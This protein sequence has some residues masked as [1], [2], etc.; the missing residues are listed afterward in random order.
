MEPDAFCFEGTFEVAGPSEFKMDRHYLLYAVQGTMRLETAGRRWTLP[1]A[2][3]ALI[4]ANETVIISILS[5]LKTAS[6]LFRPGFIE[7]PPSP[8]A[9]FEVTSLARE[10]ILECRSWG[11]DTELSP[12]ARRI[13]ATLGD[14]ALRLATTP[15]TSYLP[16]PQSAGLL[17]AVALTE[18]QFAGE[19]NFEAIAV[20]SGHTSRTLA[21]LF[22][23][24]MG[25][26]WRE[27]LRRIRII[28]AIEELSTSDKKV[29]TVALDVGYSSVAAFNSAFRELTGK[30]PVE[31]RNSLRA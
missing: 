8:V 18:E 9:V 23:A 6:V 20:A 12:Y 14:V 11:R 5:K 21:R 24:E 16:R 10:L 13:F 27:V 25:M 4:A 7:N 30:T 28:R 17:R 31:F 22:A 3:A 26:T 29:T 15:S 19:P 2:R 1:P